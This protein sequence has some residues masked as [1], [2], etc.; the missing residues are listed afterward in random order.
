[1]LEPIDVQTL[2]P[3]LQR[4]HLPLAVVA[5]L[6]SGTFQVL[7]S[8]PASLW[9]LEL[10][11]WLPCLWVLTRLEGWRALLAGW[12]VGISANIAIFWWVIHTVKTFAFMPWPLAALVLLGFSILWGGY[13]A[14]FGLGLRAVRRASGALW[15]VAA[16][17]WF[18][19]CEYLN[20]QLFPY[21]QGVTWYEQ[22]RIFLLSSLTGVSGVSFLIVLANAVLLML[23]ERR[24]EATPFA[25]PVLRNA[26][27]LAGTVAVAVLWSSFQLHRV[28]VAAAKAP[29]AKMAII[30]PNQ[31][32]DQIKRGSRKDKDWLLHDFLALS[33]EV[34]DEQPDVDV[35]VWPEGS[36]RGGPKNKRNHELVE[37]AESVQ[38]E[39]WTGTSVSMGSKAN[40]T[41]H[42]AAYR[43]D[44]EGRVDAPYLKTVLLPFGEFMPLADVFPILRKIK[45]VGNFD[46]GDGARV[47]ET[48]HGNMSY[49][50][51][52][53]A[54]RPRYVRQ[55]MKAGADLLVNGTYEGWF[56]D[57]N[58][59]H[60]HLMLA[61]VQ[62]ASHGVP[63]V[64]SATTGI[65]AFID[66]AG[67]LERTTPVFERT[68]LVG[69]VAHYTVPTPYTALGD[70]FAW[71]A[72]LGSFGLLY[73][74]ST[75]P[76]ARWDRI[77]WAGLVL[78][79]AVTPLAW[80]MIRTAPALDWITW[81]VALLVVIAVPLRG[82][83]R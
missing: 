63:M 37:F 16:A 80:L 4:R 56:G 38:A 73:R 67:R 48:P 66:A 60:Q 11:G 75:R 26:A 18:V 53:E 82:W 20:P 54:I 12:L 7:A 27:V 34:E 22:S 30:Q 70:W 21:F 14:A 52:Y 59:P 65:S 83:R 39:V 5:L 74:G 49:V 10:I 78:F 24:G 15:P 23:W 13:L 51:C 2:P 43:I 19:A 46:P 3:L 62:S 47:F 35:Y 1:M 50:I 31:S 33:Q 32:V 29:S 44:A 8:A 58:C 55:A 76:Q 41:R 45:G 69:E 81:A 61:A 72:L 42:G 71:L 77:A 57:T 40:R 9:W 6:A 64:R 79:V 68:T 25:G 17:L 36:F 28:D